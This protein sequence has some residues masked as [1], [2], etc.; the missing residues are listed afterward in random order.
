MS[1]Y[2]RFGQRD[3]TFSLW[4]RSLPNRCT[5][6]DIDFLEYCQRCRAPLALI[7]IAREVGQ[8]N[9][10]TLVMQRLAEAAGIVAY[11]VIY[12]VDGTQLDSIGN[13]RVAKVA[14]ERGEFF[15]MRPA[16]VGELITKIHDDHD[17]PLSQRRTA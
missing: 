9:K 8:E 15:N 5:C 11:V 1:R 12:T 17:C 13:C 4:H 16:Q 6:I 3:L 7:E 2:E 14:P 10:P